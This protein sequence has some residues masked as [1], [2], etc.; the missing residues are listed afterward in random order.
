M[1]TNRFINQS[2]IAILED[3][4][5]SGEELFHIEDNFVF[6]YNN[7]YYVINFV[8]CSKRFHMDSIKSNI[9]LSDFKK[10]YK[11]T[12]L[13]ELSAITNCINVS[14]LRLKNIPKLS[15]P[16]FD[17]LCKFEKYFIENISSE[18]NKLNT[19]IKFP[20]TISIN[21]QTNIDREYDYENPYG[22]TSEFPLIGYI[23]RN[24]VTDKDFLYDYFRIS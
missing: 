4:K 3:Y 12:Y 9:I 16:V 1:Y 7:I 24:I 5:K 11:L 15:L 10:L 23:I 13:N 20:V 21:A 17:F 18:T 22:E 14:N 8:I 2:T 6:L 19:L